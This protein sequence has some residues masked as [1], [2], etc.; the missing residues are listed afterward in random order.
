LAADLEFTKSD[1][2]RLI[3]VEQALALAFEPLPP[4]QELRLLRGQCG[5]IV[6]LGLR[7]ALMQGGDQARR[8]QQVT[9][10]LPHDRI[11]PVGPH[12]VRGTFRDSPT[13]QWLPPFTFIETS[14]K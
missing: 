11:Q 7:P 13:G 9:Q 2:F 5:Q 6:L 4:L 1:G 12:Q 3:R 10:G 8:S 14:A